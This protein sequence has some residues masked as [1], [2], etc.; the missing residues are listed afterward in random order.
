V[1]IKID[2]NAKQR[3]RS[4]MINFGIKRGDGVIICN[5][6]NWYDNFK[7]DYIE[8][9]CSLEGW[10]PPLRLVPDFYE[11]HVLVWPWTGNHQE[12]SM[13]GLMPYAATTFGDFSI[14]GPALNSHDGVFQ[15]PARR[16][17]FSSNNHVVDFQDITSDSLQQALE[18]EPIK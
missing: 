9:Q 17:R 3:I 13:T 16:W 11:I 2:L 7:I 6:N 12:G 10:L 18:G 15:Q 8:G 4:P 1:R 14:S 5:F